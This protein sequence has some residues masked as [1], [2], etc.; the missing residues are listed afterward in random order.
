MI[1]TGIPNSTAPLGVAGGGVRPFAVR[2]HRCGSLRRTDLYRC[3]NCDGPLVLELDSLDDPPQPDAAASGIWRLRALLPRT[4]HAITL[5]EGATPLLEL[6]ARVHRGHGTVVAKLESLNPT[7]S[8]KDR[9]MAVGASVARDRGMDGLVLTST[10]NAAVSAAAYA[11]YAGLRCRIVCA[12][13]PGAGRKLDAARAHGAEVELVEGD[14]SDA[15]QAATRLE[16]EHWLN[17]TTTYRNP[18]LAEAYRTIAFELYEQLGAI[19]GRIIVPVGAGPLLRGVLSGFEDLL[20]VGLIARLPRMVAVQAAACAPLAEAWARPDWDAS[21]ARGSFAA[22]TVAQAIADS[23]R[24]YEAEGLL[25]LDAVRRSKGTVL[26]IEDD[27]ILEA[28]S[29][30]ARGAG[31]EAEPAAAAALA[32]VPHLERKASEEGQVTTVLLTGHGAH[33]DPTAGGSSS[34]A[35]VA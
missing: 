9:A 23:L 11:A 5:G 16:A 24:G 28:T 20:T 13:R 27:A 35:S 18:F 10:G 19:P 14:Y 33:H 1:A 30:L 34:T 6:A 2:C 32:A 8:F 25:T 21:L 7:L 17:V 4:D 15:Y 12:N 22:P 31:V 29:R 3:G 26:A